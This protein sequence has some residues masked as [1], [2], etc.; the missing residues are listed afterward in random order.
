MIDGL[1]A[2]A[3]N[4]FGEYFSSGV[5]PGPGTLRLSG[6]YAGYGIYET[7]DGKYFTIACLERKFFENFCEKTGRMELMP[8]Y[9]TGWGEERDKLET[10][11]TKL[12]KQKTREAWT[13]LLAEEETCCSPVLY[14]DEVEKE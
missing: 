3:Q 13:E 14:F 10:E 1:M 9:E 4:I 12:F 5:V 6:G 7:K 8:L 2:V 11:L